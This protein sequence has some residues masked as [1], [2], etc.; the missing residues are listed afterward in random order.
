EGEFSLKVSGAD[1]TLRFTFIGYA[2]K[3]V[4]LDG[5]TSLEVSLS[6]K[7]SALEDVVVT[8]LGLERESKSLGYSVSEIESE[9][10]L[11]GT[12]TNTA[13]LLQSKVAGLNVA[14]T[15]GGPGS[16]SRITIRGASSLAGNNQPLYVVDGVPI[17]NTNFGSGGKYEGFDGGDG[18]SS[19]SPENIES[20]SVLKGAS[21]AAL[22]GSRARDGVIEIITKSGSATTDGPIVN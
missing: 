15:S 22:Y 6:P 13:N 4:A 7:V 11:S 17:D 1:A 16:S 12:E 21:A 5:E 9:D 18:I 14:P 3:N 20:I 8:A 10:L 19:I 2:A